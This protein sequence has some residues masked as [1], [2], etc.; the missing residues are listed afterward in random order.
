MKG[1]FIKVLLLFCFTIC[2]IAAAGT[3]INISED[4]KYTMEVVSEKTLIPGGQS[5]GI[6]MDVKGVLV[7]GL[8]EIETNDKI[9]SPGA[10]AGI[11]IGDTIISIDGKDVN[12]A[13]EVSSLVGTSNKKLKVEILR[14]DESFTTEITPAKDYASGQYKLGIWVKEK[15]AGIGTLTYYDPAEN[16]YGSL[17][18]GIYERKTRHLLDVREGYLLKTSVNSVIEGIDGKPGEIRGIFYQQDSPIGNVYKNSENGVFSYGNVDNVINIE[19]TPLV[20][21][22][23]NHI[24]TGKAYII[25]TLH[26]DD[27]EKFEIEITKVNKHNKVNSKDLEINVTDKKLLEYTGGIVQG[28]SGSPI[29]QEGKIVGAVTHVLVNDPTRG[30][31]IFIENMLNAS[32][33]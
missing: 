26:E 11:Q 9:V 15:I 21:A 17:G 23:K 14:K 16:I 22:S 8:E 33:G 25:S 32:K 2:F 18:H 30:Y 12:Y 1:R 6:K 29:I 5:I 13:D 27:V 4:S 31:G 20:A 28:M 19:E 10:E 24:K 7:V 3:V